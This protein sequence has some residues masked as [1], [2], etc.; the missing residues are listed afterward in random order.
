MQT[1]LPSLT[2]LTEGGKRYF[3]M[4]PRMLELAIAAAKGGAPQ[5]AMTYFRQWANQDR[6][7]AP[8]FYPLPSNGLLEDLKAYYRQ[9]EI[10]E[11]QSET[12]RRVQREVGI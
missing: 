11:P 4:T 5:V 10:D 12:P 6:R 8:H 2:V 1:L 3:P 7:L 9:I